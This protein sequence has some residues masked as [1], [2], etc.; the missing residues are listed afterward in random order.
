LRSIIHQDD[1]I[2]EVVI[3][4][5]KVGWLKWRSAFGVL[6]DHKLPMKLEGKIL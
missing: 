3:N 1:E 6:C 4:R 5:I 2:E